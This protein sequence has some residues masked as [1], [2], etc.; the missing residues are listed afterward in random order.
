MTEETTFRKLKKALLELLRGYPDYVFYGKIES[1]IKS[2]KE[3][4]DL[5]H[6]HQIID[7]LPIEEVKKLIDKMPQEEVNKL[8]LGN[9]R[10][11]WYR[12]APKGIDLTISMINLEYSERIMEYSKQTLNYSK[13]MRFF[14]I[15]IIVLG[16]LTLGLGALTFYFECCITNGM[17][18]ARQFQGL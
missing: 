1:Y 9:E 10:F 17:A 15:A 14:T 12:L 11:L 3:G 13:E 2:G 5:L 6:K 7:K 8:P 18:F 16:I 4:V